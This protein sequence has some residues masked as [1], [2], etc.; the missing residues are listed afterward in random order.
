MPSIEYLLTRSITLAISSTDT[1][2]LRPAAEMAHIPTPSDSMTDWSYVFVFRV[3]LTAM[4]VTTMSR[5]I[6]IISVF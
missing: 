4:F 1:Q 2:T 6:S 3:G 5:S